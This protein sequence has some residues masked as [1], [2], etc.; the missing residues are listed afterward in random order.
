MT[1]A[2][3]PNPRTDPVFIGMDVGSTTVKAVVVDPVTHEILWSDYQ[4]HHTKQPEKVLELLEAHR[5]RVPR[6]CRRDAWRIF[7]T[8]SG[9]APLVRAD[10]RKFV[11]EV[12][13]VTLAVEHLHPDVG[14]RHRARR[15]GREDHHVQGG[16]EDRR[17]DR[18]RLDE[19]QVRVGHRRH[20]RQVLPQGRHAAGARH[21]AALRRPQAPP[22]RRQVRRVRRDRHRQPGQERHPVERGPLLAR[23]RDRPAEP[24]GAHARQHAQAQGAAARR[25]EHLP[26]VPPGVL[27]P[28]HPADVGRARLRLPE[29]RADRRADLRPR[30]RAVL[31]GVRR[32]AVRP[33]RGRRRSA[34]TTGSRRSNEYITTGRKAR[35]GETRGPAAR[36]ATERSSTTFREL[37]KIPKFDAGDARRRAGRARASSASTAARRRPRP[38]SSTRDENILMQGVPALEGQP[39]PGHEGAARA[40]ARRGSTEQGATLEVHGLRRHRLRRR[41]ARGVRAAPT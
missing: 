21:E 34:S 23:R 22:R 9:A 38:C 19:R 41:R 35:L 4:R 32:G 2:G 5:R 8:G 25:P 6:S 17:Q 15:S 18:H 36:R 30:E 3:I 13:A 28:A 40:A 7:I 1:E 20:H 10:R 26:A 14:S 27:A 11:Q 29:G 16:R 31:R 37:Y 12:N 24:L 33:A 39:D